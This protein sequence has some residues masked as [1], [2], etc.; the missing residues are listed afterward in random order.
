MPPFKCNITDTS[1]ILKD[2]LTNLLTERQTGGWTDRLID[3]QTWTDRTI[4]REI[5]DRLTKRCSDGRLHI[6]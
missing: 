1:L 6:G 4:E 5:E 3:G 2:Q